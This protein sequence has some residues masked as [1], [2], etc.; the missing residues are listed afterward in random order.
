MKLP[1]F[2]SD[3]TLDASLIQ[4]LGW[5]LV[6]HDYFKKPLS[7]KFAFV[8]ALEPRG[9]WFSAHVKKVPF[10][11]PDSS[12]GDFIEGLWEYDVAELFITD[13]EGPS[14]Q[15]INLSPKAS[16]WTCGF[17]AYRKRQPGV[18]ENPLLEGSF[19]TIL[20]DEWLSGILIPYSLL[21][22]DLKNISKCKCNVTGIIG[23]EEKAYITYSTLST[24]EPDYHTIH[25]FSTIEIRVL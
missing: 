24:P 20:K 18:K 11:D 8:V 5:T 25:D 19:S 4:S 9:I 3:K 22:V 14:Y 7:F 23:C 1:V 2:L 12:M 13:G 10:M 16:W 17:L 6:P 21:D 15:E